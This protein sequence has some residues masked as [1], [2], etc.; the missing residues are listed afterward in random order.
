MTE[1]NNLLENHRGY[2]LWVCIQQADK[3]SKT[4]PY[5]YVELL[6]HAMD[7]IMRGAGSLVEDPISYVK[8]C[9]VRKLGVGIMIGHV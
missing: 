9:G 8:G 4:H 6:S 7:Q 2:P 1:G 5:I 3:V